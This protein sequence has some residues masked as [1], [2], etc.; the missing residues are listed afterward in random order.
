MG[1]VLATSLGAQALPSQLGISETDARESFLGSVTGGYPRWGDVAAKAF[2]ALPAATRVLVVRGGFAWA[3][4]HVKSPQFR[5]A[6][7]SSRQSAKPTPPNPVGTVEEE[8]QRQLA[9]LR[10]N[11]EESRKGLA[12]L[13]AE[14]RREL[15]AVLRQSEAQLSDRQ[16]L[17]MIRTSI[18]A[19]R[20]AEMTGYQSSLERWEE[21]WPATP[22]VLVARRLQAFLTECADVSFSARLRPEGSKMVFVNPEDEARPA[23][24]KTCYR[25]GA[26]AMG[27]A[28]TAAA[29]WL[30]ELEPRP[31]P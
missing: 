9:D 10:K 24:W 31:R 12:S 14:Q 11:F 26:E 8:L 28:R 5:A 20:A 22:D 29:A 6:Y 7:D 30:K 2:V 25:A 1:L 15:E 27:A 18:E 23:N 3:R 4:A 19:A 16:Y 13:P 17:A 21:A